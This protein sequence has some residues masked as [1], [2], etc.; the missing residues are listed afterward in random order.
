MKN[1]KMAVNG[2]SSWRQLFRSLVAEALH[3]PH[4]LAKIRTKTNHK[5]TR[6]T[7]SLV[8][9]VNNLGSLKNLHGGERQPET[10]IRRE[11]G[12]SKQVV[13]LEFPHSSK[14]LT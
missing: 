1:V 10:A 2:N 11:C 12:R 3:T 4:A 9:E 7:T 13:S 14:E 8:R 5:E 6:S